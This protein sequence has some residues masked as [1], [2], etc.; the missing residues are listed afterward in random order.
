M[1]LRFRRRRADARASEP[2]PPP[3]V[4]VVTYMTSAGIGACPLRNPRWCYREARL[5]FIGQH[6]RGIEIIFDFDQ[7]LTLETAPALA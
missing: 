1:L 4:I 2:D 6:R 7:I 3:R 5:A